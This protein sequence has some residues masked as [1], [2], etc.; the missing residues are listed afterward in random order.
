MKALSR[1]ALETII[2]AI[3]A[4][5]VVIE[6]EGGRV[7]YVNERAIQLYGV[8]PQ[9]LEMPD[10]STKLM[11][12]LTLEGKVYLPEKL[13]ASQALLNGKEAE[14]NLIIERP[15]GSRIT[16]AASAKPIINEKGKIISAIAIFENITKRKNAEHALEE[17]EKRFKLV[18]EAAKVMVYEL[19][20]KTGVVTIYRGEEVIGYNAGEIP[21]SNDW[22]TNQI[23]QQ[24]R[25]DVL[26]KTDSA[27]VQGKDIL[28]EYRVKR[29]QGDY[30]IVHDTAKMV[31]DE[32]GNV[33]RIVGGVRDVTKRRNAEEAL[34]RLKSELEHKVEERTKQL[35][36]ERERFFNMLEN[37]P[38]MVCLI[39]ADYKVPYANRLFREK[40]GEAKGRC[41]YEYVGCVNAPCKHCESFTPLQTGKPHHWT[42][43]FSDGTVVD[44]YDFPFTDV[45]GTPMRKKLTWT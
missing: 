19:D 4:G 33:I 8:N 29:K 14:D 20:V 18:A 11:K 12:L 36:I 34:S 22:W 1:E 32:K 7:S 17:S 16:V 27:I 2:Q 26:R 43:N 35:A 21:L 42:V 13:P 23:H 44:A 28:I 37:M 10:H 40:F 25:V 41:C 9:G 15:D 31:K 38:V 45:D 3:P 39:T 5:V 6:K 24:D 30:I